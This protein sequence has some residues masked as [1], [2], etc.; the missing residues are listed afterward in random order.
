M[1]KQFG[2]YFSF[3]PKMSNI[4]QNTKTNEE[5]RLTTDIIS[6][7]SPKYQV[8]AGSD[9]FYKSIKISHM[10]ENLPTHKKWL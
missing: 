5:L 2:E 8:S 9:N 3:K 6:D 1:I 7:F 10:S 4:T